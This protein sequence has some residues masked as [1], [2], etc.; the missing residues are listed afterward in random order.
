MTTDTDQER[1]AEMAALTALRAYALINREGE[2]LDQARE[3]ARRAIKEYLESSLFPVLVDPETGMTAELRV[4]AGSPEID[5]STAN[6]YEILSLARGGIL[7]MVSKTSAD[8]ICATNTRL[9]D[10]RRKYE[11]SGKPESKL[12]IPKRKG[13]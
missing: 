9:G 3:T 8:A 11:M 5:L 10:I 1:I 12:M 2:P 13:P 4:T 7:R 6:D